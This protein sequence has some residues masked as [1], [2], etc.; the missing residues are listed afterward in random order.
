MNKIGGPMISNQQNK[1]EE[2]ARSY[3]NCLIAKHLDKTSTTIPAFHS[4][5]QAEEQKVITVRV[6]RSIEE[7][8]NNGMIPCLRI[9]IEKH[10][11]LENEISFEYRPFTPFMKAQW[12]KL[13]IS[14]IE[15]SL[16]RT[17]V[18]EAAYLSI[19]NKPA[20]LF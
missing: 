12:D 17:I 16:L 1:S 6:T 20:S 7:G 10:N 9:V 15:K 2:Y 11:S 5:E 4:M 8:L 19:N 13:P 14:Q 18:R 3:L